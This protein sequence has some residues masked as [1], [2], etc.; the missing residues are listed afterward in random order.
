M[1][2]K[3]RIILFF[4]L[5]IGN[6]YSQKSFVA[7]ELKK[8]RMAYLS[9]ENFSADVKVITYKTPTQQNGEPLG[10]G[11][12]RKSKKGY[13]SKY[14]DD[15]MISNDHCTVVIDHYGKD[16]TY[17]ESETSFFSSSF[18]KMMPSSDSL[19]KSTDSVL[20]KG[21]ENNNEHFIFKSKHAAIN[22]IDMYLGF[23]D[24]FI[25]KIIYYYAPSDRQNKYDMYKVEI[26]Y[27]NIRLDKV[28]NSWFSENKIL[29]YS[30]GKPVLQ[31][32]YSSYKLKIGETYK[33]HPL[34]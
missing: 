20:Y 26:T 12:I 5:I 28:N 30:K 24:H 15:E 11:L 16:V 21:I 25:K 29:A 2:N 6:V 8:A 3:N 17:L 22:R 32:A 34:K 13:Y 10:I 23:K 7:S 9:S 14:L 18:M 19:F 1:T 4:L 31:T 27:E 33:E